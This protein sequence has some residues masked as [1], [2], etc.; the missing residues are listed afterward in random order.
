VAVYGL[1]V[2]DEAALVTD[3]CLIRGPIDWQ[4]RF[5]KQGPDLVECHERRLLKSSPQP[6]P[7]QLSAQYSRDATS[8]NREPQETAEMR[9]TSIMPVLSEADPS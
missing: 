3:T 2:L 8:G 6:S 9:P 5:L 4:V 7:E 1:K